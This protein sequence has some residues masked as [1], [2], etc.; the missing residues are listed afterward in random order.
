MSVT[1]FLYQSG[2]ANAI[3]MKKKNLKDRN[4]RIHDG[5]VTVEYPFKTTQTYRPF[6]ARSFKNHFKKQQK[7]DVV[8]FK[9]I[10]NII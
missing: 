5:S 8:L 3:F 9:L 7:Y 2:K 6:Y 1:L 4:Y 10:R